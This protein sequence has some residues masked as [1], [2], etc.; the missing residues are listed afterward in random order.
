MVHFSYN[1]CSFVQLIF[2]ETGDRGFDSRTKPQFFNASESSCETKGFF[3]WFFC[4]VFIRHYAIFFQK[5]SDS[6]KGYP[7]AFF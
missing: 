5:I 7:L 6:I 4:L 3:V 1:L 2:R